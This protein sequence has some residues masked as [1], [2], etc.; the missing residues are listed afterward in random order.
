MTLDWGMGPAQWWL[1]PENVG[2]GGRAWNQSRGLNLGPGRRALGDRPG[3]PHPGLDVLGPASVG[4]GVPGFLKGTARWADV[5]DHHRA[6]VSPQ[7]ILDGD[8]GR[9]RSAGPCLPARCSC[10]AVRDALVVCACVCVRF[11]LSLSHTHTHAHTRTHTHTHAHT[12]TGAGAEHHRT[13]PSSSAVPPSSLFQL[14]LQSS[15]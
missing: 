8:K 3:V 2:C 15:C 6:A 11:P 4:Q 14:L 7:G 12:L 13:L 9:L 5:G 1:V 10:Q